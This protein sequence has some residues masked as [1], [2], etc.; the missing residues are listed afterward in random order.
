MLYPE[1]FCEVLEPHDK[2]TICAGT[3]IPV[4]VA[5]SVVVEGWASLVNVSVALS[6][7]VACGLKL[8]VNGALWP[9]GT[10]TGSDKPLTVNC[11]LFELTAVMVTFAPLALRLPEA[12]PFDPTNTL[13]IPR[14]AGVA[15]SC[16]VAVVPVPEM[17]MT[18]DGSDPLEVIVTLPL[19]AP[20]ACGVK[21]TLKARVCPAVSVSGVEIAL[22]VKP[23]PLMAT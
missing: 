8:T 18:K 11:A 13:P 3:A 20:A 1:M 15:V 2:S 7:P 23:V 4:P 10:T 14:V 5:A 9:A 16:A 21:V 12:V 17:G 22:R 6:P 19:E